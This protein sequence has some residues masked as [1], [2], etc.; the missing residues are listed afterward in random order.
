[1]SLTRQCTRTSEEPVVFV[2]P[3]AICESQRVGEGTR[4]W[5]F[6]HI[7]DGAVIG[8]DCNIGEHAYVEGGAEIGDR[9]VLKNQ[10][11]IWEGITIEDDVFV[12]PGTIFTND[13]YPRSRGMS[14][15]SDRYARVEDWLLPT[16]VRRGASIGAGAIILAGVTI[17]RCAA[18]GAGAVVTRSVPDHRIVVGNPAHPAGWACSCGQ[19]LGVCFE[20]SRCSRRYVLNNDLLEQVQ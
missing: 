2:H 16:T 5:P 4:V 12:G 13:R 6:A 10:V 14:E 3:A 15:A 7:L 9:V 19:T 8:R 20:C 17:G 18:I 1:M 11:L